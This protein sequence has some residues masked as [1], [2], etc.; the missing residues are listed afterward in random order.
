MLEQAVVVLDV[1]VRSGKV[2]RQFCKFR[3][4][5]CKEIDRDIGVIGDIA[6]VLVHECERAEKVCRDDVR[7]RDEHVRMWRD[8]QA[9]C[10]V[11]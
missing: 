10:R 1:L 5:D 7:G 3:V 8:Y 11:E 6:A 9:V 4:K 2:R